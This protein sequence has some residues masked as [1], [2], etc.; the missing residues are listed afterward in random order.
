[1]QS[2]KAYFIF[3]FLDTVPLISLNDAVR[4]MLSLPSRFGLFDKLAG[5]LEK[6]F[7][8]LPLKAIATLYIV[9][10]LCLCML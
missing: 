9:S 7:F 5:K 1:M 8:S 3:F 2:F 6:C 4:K 10:S